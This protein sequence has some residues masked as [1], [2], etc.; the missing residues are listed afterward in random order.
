MKDE[1]IQALLDDTHNS[2]NNGESKESESI[3]EEKEKC[4]CFSDDNDK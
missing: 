2:D 1:A 4:E 3:D